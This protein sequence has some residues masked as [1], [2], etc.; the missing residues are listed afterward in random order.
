MLAHDR[1]AVLGMKQSDEFYQGN[2]KLVDMAPLDT[3][4]AADRE[5]EKDAIAVYQVADDL[6]MHQWY[7]IDGPPVNR[8]PPPVPVTKQKEQKKKG[9]QVEIFLQK[10]AAVTLPTQ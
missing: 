1:L 9:G 5:I 8:P 6:Y 4:T 7:R 10:P 3:P 2:P